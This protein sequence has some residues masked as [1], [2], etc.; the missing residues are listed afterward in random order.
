MADND[1]GD[2][3]ECV[4]R[5]TYGLV[6]PMYNVWRF[7]ILTAAG[8]TNSQLL[9]DMQRW[10]TGCGGQMDDIQW[11]GV[12]YQPCVVYN[13]TKDIYRGAVAWPRTTGSVAFSPLPSGIA[14]F[15]HFRTTERRAP[16]RKYIGGLTL[17]NL[18]G[19]RWNATVIGKLTNIANYFRG[20]QT[21][22][23]RQY[24]PG[25]WSEKDQ[26][27]YDVVDYIVSAVPAH[28]RRRKLQA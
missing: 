18:A 22:N 25:V 26:A 10:V 17:N 11:T 6:Q 5:A 21:L 7:R 19:A 2:V 3:I 9:T 24:M 13:L 23:T 8:V 20:I 12:R 27:F 28:Q 4:M 16:S 14:G 1:Q 15:I